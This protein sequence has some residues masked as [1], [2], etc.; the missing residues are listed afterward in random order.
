M[1][2]WEHSSGFRDYASNVSRRIEDAYQCGHAKVR[3]KSGKCG[4]I[5]MEVLFFDM[6]QFDPVTFNSR[7]VRR[8]GHRSLALRFRRL[9]S[10]VVRVWPGGQ[11]RGSL[12]NIDPTHSQ[13]FKTLRD[14]GGT[15]L[16]VD[17]GTNNRSF[18]HRSQSVIQSDCFLFISTAAVLFQTFLV[19]FT[20]ETGTDET[21]WS[22]VFSGLLCALFL[23]EIVVRFSAFSPTM[24]CIRDRW[25][26]LDSAL[27]LLYVQQALGLRS[28]RGAMAILSVRL[29][30]L[31]LTRRHILRPA[32]E[33]LALA[34]G[35]AWAFRPAAATA[36]LLAMIMFVFAVAFK[37]LSSSFSGLDEF[38]P[39]VMGCAISLL[40]FGVFM[41]GAVDLTDAMLLAGSRG[42]TLLFGVF[43][44]VSNFTLLNMLVVIIIQV[45]STIFRQEKSRIQ[46]QTSKDT[47][48]DLLED[49]VAANN[50]HGQIFIDKSD[51]L[52]LLHNPEVC[53]V[54]EKFGIDV[55]GL[56]SMT[57][58]I[59]RDE[60]SRR[61]KRSG[62]SHCCFS[63]NCLSVQDFL[64]VVW[65]LNGKQSMSISDTKDFRSFA[66]QCLERLTV[67]FLECTET[68]PHE[69]LFIDDCC[70]AATSEA[71]GVIRTTE[72][73]SRFLKESLD[74]IL[75][76]DVELRR[77]LGDVRQELD[78]VWMALESPRSRG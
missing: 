14:S 50:G 56:R 11:P 16:S 68:L 70:E 43:V 53:D 13:F 57:D 36:S 63:R 32:V 46:F 24:S 60:G 5:P 51:F 73:P 8:L 58:V 20:I 27:G 4:A 7:R 65:R 66:Q 47:L 3:F 15:E 39:S 18:L 52:L 72:D 61:L 75:A 23:V 21:I 69:V 49:Y 59:F 12:A 37:M 30:R 54:L 28:T 41:D 6:V 67:S 45:A 78:A 62:A 71:G 42:L 76:R 26:V 33:I 55:K 2:Q 77:S 1:W 31:G 10:D 17:C 38:F 19:W 74:D 25:F 29:L 9:V 22:R 35:M 48:L 34:K 64:N 40:M 44:F